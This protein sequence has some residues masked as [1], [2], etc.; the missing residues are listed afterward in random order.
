MLDLILV[1]RGGGTPMRLQRERVLHGATG[2]GFARQHFGGL[3]HVEVAH[4]IG[5]AE[6]QAGARFEIRRAKSGKGDRP[7]AR[8]QLGG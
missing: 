4:R 8:E 5:Q 6:Q 2:V 7:P 3:A 1:T